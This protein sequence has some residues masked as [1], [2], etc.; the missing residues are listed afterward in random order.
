MPS[1]PKLPFYQDGDYTTP[2]LIWTS[3]RDYPFS[4][5]GDL[6]SYTY[7][8]NYL[9]RAASYTPAAIG[10]VDPDEAGSYLLAETPPDRTRAPIAQ[11]ERTYGRIPASRLVYGAITY[12]LPQIQVPSGTSSSFPRGFDFFNGRAYQPFEISST[13]HLYTRRNVTADTGRPA[14]ASG[15]TFTITFNGQT[16]SALAYNA[17]AATIQN[18]I[19]ALSSVSTPWSSFAVS[20]TAI[21]AASSFQALVANQNPAALVNTSSII[22]SAGATITPFPVDES[23]QGTRVAINIRSYFA[24]GNPAPAITANLSGLTA[25]GNG[26]LINSNSVKGD[27]ALVVIGVT[28]YPTTISGTYTL[29]VGAN[30]TVP[31]A[32]NATA[33]EVLAALNALA[34]VQAIGVIA[35]VNGSTSTSP[36]YSPYP[37]I[38]LFARWVPKV[39]GGTFTIRLFSVTTAPLAYNASA[40]SIKTAVDAIPGVSARGGASVTT[41]STP[42]AVRVNIDFAPPYFSVNSASLTPSSYDYSISPAQGNKAHQYWQRYP[43]NVKR[44]LTCPSHGYVPGNTVYLKASV[45][46]AYGYTEGLTVL[47]ADTLVVDPAISPWNTIGTISELGVRIALY[48]PRAVRVRTRRTLNYYLPGVSVGISNLAD[49]PLGFPPLSDEVFFNQLLSGVVWVPY[50]T[51]DPARWQGDIYEL[52][53]TEIQI[54]NLG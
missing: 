28:A 41:S 24:A 50:E 22:V 13:T 8:R 14:D 40:A 18:A 35:E 31:L 37:Q 46:Y 54:S 42:D 9:V 5:D 27:T 16:T 4:N 33:A 36:I 51:S 34:S 32:Y 39:T 53:Q 3:G 12:A 47:D 6:A 44:R 25:T 23:M 45:D 11:I 7:R 49:L 17:T 48:T 30:T 19:N 26:S 10:S 1:L 15:G 20:S 38:A 52:A 2:V 29:T 21:P 43:F